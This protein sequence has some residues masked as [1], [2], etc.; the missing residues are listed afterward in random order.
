MKIPFFSNGLPQEFLISTSRYAID[1]VI[2]AHDTTSITILNTHLEGPVKCLFHILFRHLQ[3]TINK[4]FA[5]MYINFRIRIATLYYP[6]IKTVALSSKPIVN[7]IGS[8]VLARCRNFKWS[9]V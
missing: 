1:T 8:K 7:I 2:R 3:K 6:S 5:L 4:Y 9:R